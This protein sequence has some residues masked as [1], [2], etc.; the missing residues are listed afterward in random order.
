[1]AQ[2]ARG[3][4]NPNGPDWVDLDVPSRLPI[5]PL[6]S[7]VLFP[8]GVLSLQV[9]IDRNVRLL[10]SLPDDQNLI[11]AFCQKSGDK[12]NPKPEDLAQIGVLAAIVQ[13]LPLSADR[14]QLF[15]QGRQRVEL[16]QMLQNEPYFEARLREVAPRPIPKTVKTDQLMGKAL[17]LFEKLVESDSK[18]SNELLNV[19]RSNMDEGPDVF[20][21]L[22]SSF[23]NFPLEE[24]QLLLETVNPIER[25]E[26]LIEWVQRDLGRATVDRELQRQI[27][28]SI[29]RRDRENYL[30]EQLRIIQDELGETN[31]AEREADTYRDRIEALPLAEEH[32][33]QLRREVTRMGQL[34]QSSSDYAVIKGHLDTV[35]QLPWTQ[36][37]DDRLDLQKAEEILDQRHYGLE[38]VK[39][40]VL[41]FLAVLKLKGDLKGPILCFVGP[42]GVG[43]TSLGAAIA[44]ALGRKFVRMAVG[45]VTDESEIRGHRKTYI[46]AM[47]GK[48]INSYT[49]VGVN[50]PLIMIDEIDKIGKDFRGDPSSALLE[51]LDP[52]QNHAFVDRYLEIPFDLSHTLFVCTA[53]ILDMIPGP[54]RD[55]ME[56]IRLSGYTENE[57]LAIATRHLVPELLENHGLSSEQV[58]IDD[59]AILHII[60][61]Y[62]AESGVRNLERSLAN[63]LRKIA[64]KVASAEPQ[65]EGAEP[66]HYRVTAADV[67][68][69]LGLPKYEHEFAERHPE[70]GVTTGL[71]WTQFGG[72]IMFIEATRM[73]GTGRTT[74]TGQLGD[75]M[76]ESVQAAYSYVR[77]KAHE[78]DIED[79]QFTEHDIH[80]HFPAGAI[81]KDGPSAGVAIATCIA[82]V[83]GERPVRHDV[84]M[85]G[86]IT[87]RGKVLSVGGIKEKVMAAHRANIKTVILPAG[88]RKDLT[89]VPEEIRAGLQFLFAE[90]VEDV[91]KETLIPLYLVKDAHDRKYDEAEY[92]AEHE[93]KS[94]QDRGGDEHAERR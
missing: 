87:L 67:E 52:K 2:T 73:P 51:V 30:R 3:K 32:K 82:S 35:L 69:Y 70:I 22:I 62:T 25:I 49:Q 53:N 38:K 76:R 13:R 80:I 39:E 85:T 19:V 14:Y 11:A 24:K 93:K 94:A 86:E 77:S 79:R 45:G 43:K 66:A 6:V 59:D 31:P 64:R 28:T 16:V 84:A 71:A 54:L 5:I 63:V 91:W 1:M 42:P 4:S 8:G 81:P 29:D 58:T 44:D 50:N 33:Q 83:M 88:N 21:D 46:G 74:V 18:Y 27:Q 23:V 65:A 72:E 12:E 15:L 40:R 92:R 26:L 78:L 10:K 56:V 37:T 9:G 89:E 90:R 48:L 60:R 68:S 61:D 17:S 7:S 55:R 34:S 20:A 57:K 75:V 41:E 36:H 47:P